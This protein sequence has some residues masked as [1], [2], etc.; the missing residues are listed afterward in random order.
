LGHTLALNFTLAFATLWS[1]GGLLVFAI[2]FF[3]SVIIP[4]EYT[5]VSAAFVG[6]LAYLVLVQ[7]F[8]RRYPVDGNALMSGLLGNVV[9]HRTLLWTGNIPLGSIYSIV[10]SI[11]RPPTR[12]SMRHQ[13]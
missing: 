3:L 4:G 2:T 10:E 9:D 11:N 5:T 1:V 13:F 12:C 7:N 8:M 6:Y